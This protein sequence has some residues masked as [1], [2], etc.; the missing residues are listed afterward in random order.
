MFSQLVANGL[1]AASGYV[2]V[3]LGL[4]MVY[5]TARFIHFAHAIIFTAGAYF[6]LLYASLLS[7]TLWV[8]IL[9]AI[10]S[11]TVLGLMIEFAVYRPLRRRGSSSLV[12]LVASL[13]VYIVI[14]NV[15]SLAFGDQMRSLRPGNPSLGIAIMG[16]RVTP[17]QLWLMVCAVVLTSGI[18]AVWRLTSIGRVLRAIA[19]DPELAQVVGVRPDRYIAF[20][21]GLAS[22]LA[23]VAGILVAFD[24]DMRPTMGFEIFLMAFV[25]F[26]IGRGR[27]MLGLVLG[28]VGVAAAQQAAG[29]YFGALWQ[30]AIAFILLIAFLAVHPHQALARAPLH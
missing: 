25:A 6:A 12:Q 21:I 3:G 16:A 28:A 11:A 23:S 19:S 14:Q 1:I 27:G 13:G 5:S 30:D 4:G 8:A 20:T 15:I 10:A 22:A 9:V 2:L 18:I 26:V 7:V 24:L 17:A 29:W